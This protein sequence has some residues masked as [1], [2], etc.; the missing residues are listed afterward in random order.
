MKD[1][2]KIM[3]PPMIIIYPLPYVLYTWSNARK[4]QHY[5]SISIAFAGIY[6]IG[7]SRSHFRG[8]PTRSR[9]IFIF[10]SSPCV[11]ASGS[12]VYYHIIA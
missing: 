2:A 12:T 7:L 1:P 9:H 4:P 5:Y 10:K 6:F 11:K 8:S 3:Q